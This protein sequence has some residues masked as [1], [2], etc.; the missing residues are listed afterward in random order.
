MRFFMFVLA[1]LAAAPTTPVTIRVQDASGGPIKDELV[2]VQDLQNKEKEL[3]RVLTDQDGKVPDL[4]LAPG[5]YRAIAT[6]PFGFWET[7]VHEFLVTE[8]PT[9]VLLKVQAMPTHGYG[10]VFV[11]PRTL[12]EL[13]VLAASG[14]PASGADVLIRDKAANLWSEG[15]F[16]TNAD[17]ITTI[18]LTGSPTVVVIVYNDVLVT[19][20]LDQKLSKVV[21]QLSAK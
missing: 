19:K 3:L 6:A 16:R 18:P 13:R 5:I 20:E 10:D 4:S 11:V 12:V 17:G 7:E 1:L 8:K 15:W 21:I 2:V 14:Q 9:E